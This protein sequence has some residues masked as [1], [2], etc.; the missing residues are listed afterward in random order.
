MAGIGNLLGLARDALSAQGFALNVT[1]QN[2]ANAST[3]GYVR[4][5]AVLETVIAGTVTYGGVKATTINRSV[6]TFLDSRTYDAGSLDSSAQSR[7]QALGSIEN[8]FNDTAGTGLSSSLSALASS[9]SALGANPTDT[10]TRAVLLDNADQFASRIRETS[11]QI[12]TQRTDLLT[13]AQGTTKSVNEL[14]SQIAKLNGQISLTENTG[15]DGSDLK[16]Q[17]DKLVTQLS[18]DI[19]VHV[20]TDG[21]GKLVI[22]T[23][24]STLVEGDRAASLSIGTH[25]DGSLQIT[26][27]RPSGTDIDIT[28]QVTGGTLG[29]ITEARDVDAVAMSQKLDQFAYDMATALN[30]QHAAGYGQD[31]VTG[32]NLFTIGGVAGAAATIAL[33]PAMVGHPERLAAAST[34][35]SLPAGADNALAIAGVFNQSVA[36]GGTRTFIEAYS[37]LVGEIGQRKAAAS[38]NADLR[39]A[40]HT[41]AKAMRESVSGVS[42]DEEM[43]KMSTFERSYQAASKLLTTADE[44]LSGLIQS[45]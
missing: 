28:G 2:I 35:A 18:G 40:I 16:D 39:S 31:G 32:R 29:G 1:G 41:Q 45:L 4:R 24:G 19:N 20:F 12:A 25:T 34:A 27:Q 26:L 22:A 33:D 17:R 30:T 3:P 44:L 15:G 43:V 13:Q 11:N 42:M 23:G 5:D 37:D 21:S 36:S 7:D 6:D 38:Q 9:F 8:L 14:A 10:T